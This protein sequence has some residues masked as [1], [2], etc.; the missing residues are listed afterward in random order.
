ME[1]LR[2]LVR[3]ASLHT[4][5]ET[6]MPVLTFDIDAVIEISHDAGLARKI[7]RLVPLGVVKG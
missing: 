4:L 3:A 2:N 6:L 7:A 1:R 5:A